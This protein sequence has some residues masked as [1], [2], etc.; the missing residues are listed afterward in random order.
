MSWTRRYVAV[1]NGGD[2][3]LPITLSLLALALALLFIT[4]SARGSEGYQLAAPKS[5]LV[6]GIQFP[7]GVAVDQ[8]SH[9]VYVAVVSDNALNQAP[10]KIRRFESNGDDAGTFGAGQQTYFGGVAVNPVTHGFYGSQGQAKTPIGSF[11]VA[12]MVPFS[13]AGVAGS[14]FPL[15]VNETIPQIATDSTGDVYFPN[16]AMNS[17]QVFNSAGALQETISCGG[18]PGGAFGEPVSVAIDS[19]NSLYVADS[20][21]D[22]VVKLTTSGGAYGFNSVLQSGRG[23]AAVGVDP[24]TDEVFVGDMPNGTNYHVVAYDSS[25]SQFD[26]FGAGLFTTPPL[27]AVAAAQIAADATTHR[28]YLTETNK[29][30]IFER[31]TII[32]PSVTSTGASAIGQLTATLNATVNVNGHAALTCQFEYTEEADIGFA[33]ATSL[34]CTALPTGSGD[35]TVAVK[36]STLAPNTA[37]RYRATVTNNGGSDGSTSTTFKTLPAVPP[38]VTMES[39]TA[40]T[41]T[42]ATVKAKANP[43]GGS[44]SSCRFEFGTSTSYG[45]DVL[46]PSLPGPVTTDVALAQQLVGLSPGTTYHYRLVLSTNAG[47]TKGGDVEFKTVSAP[48][49]S[50]PTPES[51]QPLPVIVGPPPPPECKKGFR[52]RLTASGDQCVKVCKKGFRRKRVHGEVR[53][54]KKRPASRSARKRNGHRR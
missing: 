20:A 18:C 9:R 29:V 11:G 7:H 22:R 16:A 51:S 5:V 44:V 8:L 24:S 31:A 41:Q 3:R 32:P 19:E 50:E 33:D 52:L 2:R 25:G 28:L 39:P 27:G 17:V 35:T 34:P 10:G 30:Y 40:L 36:V 37:Y 13:S 43:H 54:V 21:P 15:S 49:R 14:P 26:D 45:S 1:S 46:C 4:D 48:P 47:T 23:A 12:Q 6:S 53:C 42:S 38:T